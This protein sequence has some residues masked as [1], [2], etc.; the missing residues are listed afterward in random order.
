MAD[1]LAYRTE[2]RMR[3]DI[4]QLGLAFK[5]LQVAIFVGVALQIFTLHEWAYSEV[6]AGRFNAY[7]ESTA[8]YVAIGLTS[9]G[10]CNNVT[11][12]YVYQGTSFYQQPSC[13][14]LLV[15]EIVVKSIGAVSFTTSVIEDLEIGWRCSGSTHTAKSAACADIGAAVEQTGDQ[16]ACSSSSMYYV[17]G[18]EKLNIVLEHGYKTTEK[19]LNGRKGSSIVDDDDFEDGSASEIEPVKTEISFLNGS[20]FKNFS[21]GQDVELT[22]EELISLNPQ[23]YSLLDFNTAV[24]QD[25]R[26]STDSS[27]CDKKPT[28]RTTGMKV[29]V[30]IK[31]SNLLDGMFGETAPFYASDVKKIDASIEVNADAGWAGAGPQA[32]HTEMPRVYSDGVESYERVIRYRQSVEVVARA[33]GLVYG[34]DLTHFVTVLL[35]AFLYLKV[36]VVIMDFVTFNL[37]PHGLSKVLYNKRAE[38]VS[39]VHTFAQ[40][41]LKAA[42]AVKD[43]QAL[44]QADGYIE[45]KDIV[46]QFGKVPSVNEEQAQMI[47]RTIMRAADTDTTLR[48]RISF[49][50]FMSLFEGADGID[51]EEY[52]KLVHQTGKAH[53]IDQ[54][55]AAAAQAAYDAAETGHD[56]D[57]AA[58]KDGGAQV[59]SS[60]KYWHVSPCP[61][62]SR[63]PRPRD[64]PRSRRA[65]ALDRMLV[66]R[67]A[68]TS[69]D[70]IIDAQHLTCGLCKTIF[71]VPPGAKLVR[72]AQRS[73]KSRCR[74]SQPPR[75]GVPPVPVQTSHVVAAGGIQVPSMRERQLHRA[76]QPATGPL[77]REP[78]GILWKAQPLQPCT[79]GP[80][81]SGRPC[82]A[83]TAAAGDHPP[84][85]GRHAAHAGGRACQHDHVLRLHGGGVL[86]DASDFFGVIQMQ[87]TARSASPSV[88]SA[89]RAPRSCAIHTRPSEH[90]RPR[91]HPLSREP[92]GPNKPNR[93]HAERSIADPNCA[94]T[95][96]MEPAAAGRACAA[97]LAA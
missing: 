91:V 96:R 36:A 75:L 97:G 8:E 7:G 53:K 25:S 19:I 3:V 23:G 73:R 93:R 79:Y 16:C 89:I 10:Y 71:G 35:S 40:I 34:A 80:H 68:A 13:R 83:A 28:F 17:K 47:A 39:R 45:I 50:E 24:Q 62:S 41:G 59:A 70:G 51:F 1:L 95:R 2:R 65:H 20:S 61:A 88:T 48:G 86:S 15:E 37:L 90:A 22:L 38:R 49:N 76:D 58:G 85:A 74:E 30:D 52:V 11:H 46:Q 63:R 44:A 6:P 77:R 32:I 92:R 43:F 5:V 60:S 64:R 54:S 55:E 4:W 94:G 31:Y 27:A 21:D 14:N 81:D 87:S 67:Q 78:A 9:P 29:T 26:C 56:L 42:V 57:K 12:D 69:T 33:S 82:R 18:V 84:R 72:R 66:W